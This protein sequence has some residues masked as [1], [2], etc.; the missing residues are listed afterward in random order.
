MLFGN[1]EYAAPALSPDGAYLA[2]LRPDAAGVLNVWVRDAVGAAAA[3]ASADRVVTSDAYRGI[4][5]FFWAEDSATDSEESARQ[6][7]ARQSE[8]ATA[9]RS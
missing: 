1:P 3:D 8:A 2:F 7:H 9:R 5:Q 6:S 4:R